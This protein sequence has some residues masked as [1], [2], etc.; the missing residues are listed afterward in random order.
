L[1]LIQLETQDRRRAAERKTTDGWL[2]HVNPLSTA[3]DG[4]QVVEE[5]GADEDERQ[6][7]DAQVKAL[8]A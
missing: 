3:S 4:A 8:Q 6:R 5:I 2:R 7:D 1:L